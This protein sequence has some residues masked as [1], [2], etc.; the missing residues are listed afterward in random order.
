MSMMIYTLI[1]L[2]YNITA[3]NL[4]ATIKDVAQIVLSLLKTN[5][6]HCL[7]ATNTWIR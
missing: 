2:L 7:R 5:I 4:M 1:Q 6:I 3:T